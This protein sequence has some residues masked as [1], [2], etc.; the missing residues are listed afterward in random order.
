MSVSDSNL[1]EIVNHER[2]FESVRESKNI[3]STNNPVT[4]DIKYTVSKPLHLN[5]QVSEPN[6]KGPVCEDTKL[7]DSP[8]VEYTQINLAKSLEIP[9]AENSWQSSDLPITVES[10]KTKLSKYIFPATDPPPHANLKNYSKQEL[11]V[12]LINLCYHRLDPEMYQ[13]WSDVLERDPL[14]EEVSKTGIM[15]SSYVLKNQKDI[16]KKW[17]KK[18]AN[19]SECNRTSLKVSETP[20]LF[21][22]ASKNVDEFC[23]VVNNLL[24]SAINKHVSKICRKLLLMCQNGNF[25]KNNKFKALCNRLT[26][27]SKNPC[28]GQPILLKKCKSLLKNQQEST[29]L[30]YI[31]GFLYDKKGKQK[32]QTKT[33]INFMAD[34]GS[35]ISLCSKEAFLSLGGQLSNLKSDQRYSISSSTEIKV[36]CV[37]GTAELDI[38]LVLKNKQNLDQMQLAKSKLNLLVGSDN[39][40]ME[41]DKFILGTDFLHQTKAHIY[42]NGQSFG[43]TAMLQCQNG[44]VKRCRLHTAKSRDNFQIKVHANC[45]NLNELNGITPSTLL[46]PYDLYI[47]NNISLTNANKCQVVPSAHILWQNKEHQ[48]SWPNIIDANK[49]TILGANGW[50]LGTTHRVSGKFSSVDAEHTERTGS[51]NDESLDNTS[52]RNVTFQQNKVILN[53][54]SVPGA[55]ESFSF[56]ESTLPSVESSNTESRFQFWDKSPI[57]IGSHSAS[58]H[59]P[60]HQEPPPEKCTIRLCYVCKQLATLC[61]CIKE[62]GAEPPC[63]Q[64]QQMQC[65]CQVRCPTCNKPCNPV[66]NFEIYNNKF[67][68]CNLRTHVCL[69]T[70]VQ[71]FEEIPESSQSDIEAS[72]NQKLEEFN[73]VFD[74]PNLSSHESLNLSRIKDKKVMSKVATL[75]ADYNEIFSISK[76]D[77]G[78]FKHMVTKIPLISPT[79]KHSEPERPLRNPED[80]DKVKTL[81]DE[82]LK[83]DIIS[84]ADKIDRFSSN[85]IVVPKP[86]DGCDASKAAEQIR[87]AQGISRDSTRVCLDLRMCNKITVK[88]PPIILPTYKDLQSEFSDCYISCFDLSGFF[89]ALMLDYSSQEITNFWF[90]GKLYKFLRCP[91]GAT[92]SSMFA[93]QAGQMI[94]SDTNLKLFAESLGLQLGSQEFSFTSVREILRIYI[95]DICIFTKQHLGEKMHALI[96][97]FVFFCVKQ[98]G[99]K[100]AKKKCQ[101]FCTKF[102]FLGHQFEVGTN[103]VCIPDHKRLLFLDYRSPRSKAECLSR[104]G[105]L[106]YFRNFLPLLE[107]VTL[108]ISKMAHSDQEFH[109]TQH[110]EKCWQIVKLICE[111]NMENSVIDKQKTLYIAADASQIAAAYIIFQIDN[112]GEILMIYTATRILIRSA[113]GK[114]AAYRELLS[115]VSAVVDFEHE[116]RQ[117]PGEVV[118]L[119]DSISIS[120]LIRQKSTNN[121]MLEI[122]LLLSSFG[123]LSLYYFPGNAQFL[124]D[125]LSRQ[126]NKVFLENTDTT[127]SKHFAEL[128]PPEN[129]KYVG[130]TINCKQFRDLLLCNSFAEHIDCFSKRSYYAMNEHRYLP[131]SKLKVPRTIP[132]EVDWLAHLYF[133]L[134][135]PSLSETQLKE[136]SSQ[137]HQFPIT[138]LK[139]AS[140]S[141]N[142]QPLRHKLLSLN[143][144]QLFKKVLMKKY[145]PDK[146]QTKET[147]PINIE[148]ELI[149]LNVPLN[150]RGKIKSAVD[151]ENNQPQSNSLLI[152]TESGAPGRPVIEL[153]NQEIASLFGKNEIELKEFFVPLLQT[154]LRMFQIFSKHEM[155]DL[156]SVCQTLNLSIQDLDSIVSGKVTD[157]TTDTLLRFANSVSSAMTQSKW[158]K[159]HTIFSLPYFNGATNLSFHDQYIDIFYNQPVT[160]DPFSTLSI[161]ADIIFFTAQLMN[162]QGSLDFGQT[163]I[164]VSPSHPPCHHIE[165]VYIQNMTPKTLEITTDKKLG[166]FEILTVGGKTTFSPEFEKRETLIKF[167]N[168]FR[169]LNNAE[170]LS[171]ITDRL[172]GCASLFQNSFKPV[173]EAKQVISCMA[174]T[175]QIDMGTLPKNKNNKLGNCNKTIDGLNK[176]LFRQHLLHSK[177]KTLQDHKIAE[178]Q[179]LD[180]QFA[181]MIYKL[182]NGEAVEEFCLIRKMLFKIVKIFG[183]TSYLLCLPGFLCNDIL[184]ALHFKNDRHLAQKG[185]VDQYSNL[186]YTAN[187]IGKANDVLKKCVSCTLAPVSYVKRIKGEK[188]AN[189]T[190]TTPGANYVIDCAYL[191]QS[192]RGYKFAL[193]LV[194][195]LTSF[196]SA[197]PLKSLTAESL[198]NAYR[199][200]TSVAGFIC[201]SVTSDHGSEFSSEFSKT[202]SMLGITHKN[203]K[204]QRSQ[205]SGAA[206]IA[207]RTL[208]ASLTKVCANSLT[209][210][211]WDLL[212][213]VA[214]ANLNLN[215]PYDCPINRLQLFYSPFIFQSMPMILED[216]FSAQQSSYTFLNNK[217]ISQLCKLPFPK[218]SKLKL[219]KDISVGN[220]VLLDAKVGNKELDIC[221]ST[222][223]YRVISIND[224]RMIFSLKNMRTEGIIAAT[225]QRISPL[226]PTALIDMYSGTDMF[227]VL[228]KKARIQRNAHQPGQV[229]KEH[230]FIPYSPEMNVESKDIPDES[231]LQQERSQHDT[232]STVGDP[233]LQ[234]YDVENQRVLH[235][236]DKPEI[237]ITVEAVENE[238]G[239]DKDQRNVEVQHPGAKVGTEENKG[240]AAKYSLRS[241][242]VFLTTILKYKRDQDKNVN[243][244]IENMQALESL[245]IYNA[246]RKSLTSHY[247]LKLCK[248]NCAIC[249]FYLQAKP[250]KY[251]AVSTKNTIFMQRKP[252]NNN[253]KVHFAEHPPSFQNDKAKTFQ[254]N[255][256]TISLAVFALSSLQETSLASL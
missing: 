89:F 143:D 70:A 25:S 132:T 95:D 41:N 196:V 50:K 8:W 220:Y 35:E 141:T 20:D 151:V 207:I 61:K 130:T 197:V 251:C 138:A 191:P 189:E 149:K 172:T 28:I 147:A 46:L 87:K 39:L 134:N 3:V 203:N 142:L 156:Q 202:L 22:L 112:D 227:D 206:E 188:R 195:R 144:S 110:F 65:T 1:V 192:N 32:L 4:H 40:N 139:Q 246:F 217:R 137:L 93:C 148:Q 209:S 101:L 82:L 223:I 102:V 129:S 179:T 113:R 198:S 29:N 7:H 226:T 118:I 86:S 62:I 104:L 157:V 133:G 92:N 97:Q 120:L 180:K 73:I 77:V 67:C 34:S 83:Y 241:R 247:N 185:M 242:N 17:I 19:L 43:V 111:L 154:I 90:A 237:G 27:L 240:P 205:A 178:L 18:Q 176:L 11:F 6:A 31:Q 165:Y 229:V 250:Y 193:I 254:V 100:L 158:L 2:E 252:S 26:T 168:E 140:V 166:T 159:G 238:V 236:Q 173:G 55:L 108:P 164:Y 146:L 106:N 184:S 59:Q 121:K 177:H 124:A 216:P 219:S 122:S 38:Y 187:V 71:S 69:K 214:V 91:M 161:E 128:L 245:E 233:Q 107:L 175:L 53:S 211:N 109:W 14:F 37:M 190:D 5:S 212:L 12:S 135:S 232:V 56:K 105:A 117:H 200:F 98:S 239:V 52:F 215:R 94:F 116:I 44:E 103:V 244:S 79:A 253:K 169:N 126:Y 182:Q 222:D 75:L 127:I 145:S 119:S 80:F 174:S 208:K 58:L 201:E 194:D 170:I 88:L 74:D 183:Q 171:N 54:L 81:I 162:F 78:Q 15:A 231:S 99:V 167:K 153:S 210:K 213:P 66:S 24:L 230:N 225:A 228:A 256:S 235:H 16:R 72:L 160:V 152:S 243:F 84:P 42:S 234:N 23:K 224:D 48:H 199:V 57:S 163:V 181:N 249:D 255:F 150:L 13:T 248:N 51:L 155:W 136:L 96:I 76:F 36:D 47:R 85:L 186:F 30:P 114:S 9:A 204:P 10:N 60:L 49:C 68:I 21:S 221:P 45:S 33:L 125:A 123:N 64:C 218:S 63:K 115:I 131:I